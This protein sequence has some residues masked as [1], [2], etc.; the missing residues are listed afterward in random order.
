M[1]IDTRVI[2]HFD[3][4]VDFYG[5]D[6]LEMTRQDALVVEK[7]VHDVQAIIGRSSRAFDVERNK[8]VEKLMMLKVRK[9]ADRIMKVDVAMRRGRAFEDENM[10]DAA[11]V[12]FERADRLWGMNK[13]SSKGDTVENIAK[14]LVKLAKVM[15]AG[16][17]EKRPEYRKPMYQVSDGIQGVMGAAE[18]I[19]DKDVLQAV[20]K[21]EKAYDEFRKFMDRDFIWD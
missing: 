15:V 20:K 9:M 5:E 7:L 3:D 10:H 19:G 6:A 13:T 18:K 14:E 2:E 8:Q 4:M 1:G 21:L 17:K 12:F 16:E 11:H